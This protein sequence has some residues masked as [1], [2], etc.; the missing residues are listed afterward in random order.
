MLQTLG[1]V[2]SSR[3]PE[4]AQ[5]ATSSDD[6]V[7][8]VNEATELLLNRGDWTGTVVPIYI[9]IRRGCVTMPRYVRQVRELNI[10]SHSIPINN[11]WYQFVSRDFYH[12]CSHGSIRLTTHCGGGLKGMN[13]IGYYS[14]YNDLPTNCYIRAYP[15]AA[16]DFTSGSAKTLT[17]FGFDSNGIRLQTKNNDGTYSDGIVL[18]LASPYVQSSV[19]VNRIERVIKDETQGD[20]RLYGYEPTNNILYD[21][22]VYGTTEVNPNYARYQLQASSASTSCGVLALVKLAFIPVKY[23]N[24][25]V[26]IGNMRALKFAVQSVKAHEAGDIGKADARLAEAISE[27]NLELRND[28]PDS[29]IPINIRAFGTAHPARHSIGRIF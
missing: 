6:F 16:V 8:L 13:A 23:D 12:S 24:D 9:C 5:S 18:T 28:N 26:L 10:C 17:I 25:L 11:V 19:L 2:K 27:L 20:V 4:I 3:I 1:T 14:T 21:L 29:T 7:S 15:S 22:A